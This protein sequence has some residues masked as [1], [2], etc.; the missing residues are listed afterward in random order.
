[1][2][3]KVS[4]L[5]VCF[6][7]LCLP[8]LAKEDIEINVRFPYLLGG[9]SQDVLS[10]VDTP[11]YIAVEKKDQTASVVHVQIKAPIGMQVKKTN[12]WQIEET[13]A[14]VVLSK[15][16]NLAYGYDAWFDLLYFKASENF[17]LGENYLNVSIT[18]ND[19]S[20]QRKVSFV[21]K[22]NTIMSS[23]NKAKEQGWYIS[24]VVLPVTPE[25]HTDERA[26]GNT[27]Y[28]KDADAEGLRSRVL[29]RGGVNWVGFYNTPSTH[30]LI[31]I[32]NYFLDNKSLKLQMV[33]LDKKTGRQLDGLSNLSKDDL[34]SGNSSLR[35]NLEGKKNKVFIVPV[36]LDPTIVM[37]G[38]YS[39]R[40]S[41][42]DDIT[43]KTQ[44]V[45]ISITKERKNLPYVL[46]ATMICI[47]MLVWRIYRLKNIVGD[48]GAKPAITIALFAAIS[49]GGIVV[50]T[51]V[52]GDV[53]HVIL[54]PFSG[55]ISGLLTQLLLYML[56]VSL[57]VVCPR[58]GVVTLMLGLKW[59]LGA[60]VFGRVSPIGFSILAVNIVFLELMI[61]LSGFYATKSFSKQKIILIAVILGVGDAISTYINLELLMFFYR[62]YY[63]DWYIALLVII[64]GFAYTAIGSVLGI[65]I[66]ERLRQVTGE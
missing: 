21:H 61:W 37:D 49:F 1:M 31:D 28:I 12:N 48:M 55:F 58:P 39:I 65:K 25:G 32:A 18:G 34:Q 54:G 14:G 40:L 5:I 17:D 45:P 6:L 52:L 33:L 57:L 41:V 9:S 4:L 60:L 8:A 64:N 62:L 38:S 50:P 24:R 36:Y 59:L 42:S 43:T 51:T 15:N 47:G 3:G 10:N 35:L 53:L 7:F 13:T 16:V 44:D 19:F 23:V 63:A 46:T 27:I 30:M 22:E 56:I 29:G 66:G 20:M 2:K 11:F 26:A